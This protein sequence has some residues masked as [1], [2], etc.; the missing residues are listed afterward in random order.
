[1]KSFA[2][3]WEA[4]LSSGSHHFKT[5][6]ELKLNRVLN[7]L[8]SLNYLANGFLVVSELSILVILLHRDADRYLGYI[9]PFAIVNT[10]HPLLITLI[11]FLKNKYGTFRVTYL[12]TIIYTTYCVVLSLFLGEKIG[13]HLILFSVMPIVFIIYDYGKWFD[14]PLYPIPDDIAEVAGYL[15]WFAALALLFIYSV[16]N[17]KQVH[18]TENLL[19]EEKD[20]TRELLNETIPKLEMAEAKYRHLVDD[21]GDMIFQMN[22]FA[23]ILTMNKTARHILGFNPEEMT[24]RSLYDFIPDGLEGDLELN[25]GIAREQMREFIAG[26]NHTTFRVTLR[27]KHMYEPVDV[28]ISLQKNTVLGQQDI[29]G[30]ISKLDEDIAQRFLEKEKGRYAI[31][32]NV[33]H[34]EILSQKLAERLVRYFTPTVVN[35]IRICFREILVNAIE[36]GNL[37]ITFDEKSQ[38]IERSDYMEFLIARQKEARYANRLVYVD[39]L[40]NGRV[41]MFRITDEGEGFDHRAFLERAQKDPYIAML[42]HGRGIIMTRNVFDTVTFNEKG[43]QVILTKRIPR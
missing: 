2:A 39:Y 32:N 18:R 13:I 16:Y 31:T 20:Q 7:L 11:I 12:S 42:E 29:I 3:L 22:E 17:W 38:A 5:A 6:T 24:G 4:Y 41:L 9:I 8:F 43:N 35:T 21:S 23:T 10:L 33:T 14:V 1:M 19:A 25:R 37:G 15:C 36:H 40:I 27:K 34:A 28:Q 30:K 26:K